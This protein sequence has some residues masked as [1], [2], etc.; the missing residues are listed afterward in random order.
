[1]GDFIRQRDLAASKVGT[2]IVLTNH[3]LTALGTSRCHA[4]RVDL[5]GAGVHGVEER[6]HFITIWVGLHQLHDV[7]RQAQWI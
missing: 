2:R 6:V 1:M 5:A 7:V 3:Q 4:T